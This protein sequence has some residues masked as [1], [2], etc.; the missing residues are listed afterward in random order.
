[1]TFLHAMHYNKQFVH[2]K[3]QGQTEGPTD[4]TLQELLNIS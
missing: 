1:M 4:S 3:G 2:S